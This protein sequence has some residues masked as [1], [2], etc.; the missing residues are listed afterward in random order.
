MPETKTPAKGTKARASSAVWTDEERA[1]MK[2]SVRERKSAAGR[3][4]EQERA[5]GE[6]EVVHSVIPS[7]DRV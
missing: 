1:A 5:E 2:S 7:G 6:R 3:T 4:P